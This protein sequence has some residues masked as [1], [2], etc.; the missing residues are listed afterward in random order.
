MVNETSK[1]IAVCDLDGIM[2]GANE[3]TKWIWAL[4]LS[5]FTLTPHTVWLI[6]PQ[7]SRVNKC[8]NLSDIS[9]PYS[10]GDCFRSQKFGM[11]L[12][13]QSTNSMILTAP[14]HIP[15]EE[16]DSSIGIIGYGGTVD[17]FECHIN[18]C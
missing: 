6:E 16:Q 15:H 17:Q 3:A 18:S 8:A 13:W 5:G 14:L 4:A 2:N 9:T 11:G 12:S 1:C 10:S 7:M